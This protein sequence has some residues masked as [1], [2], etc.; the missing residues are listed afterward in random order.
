MFSDRFTTEEN[1]IIS[2]TFGYL[3]TLKDTV[4]EIDIDLSINKVLDPYNSRLVYTYA[5]F[6]E[7]F[8]KMALVLKYWNKLRFPNKNERLNS[9]SVVL[10]LIAFLQKYKVLPNLQLIGRNED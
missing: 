4:Y 9:Y 6:D 7:R 3:L 1:R 8:H 5:T 2:N 10:M